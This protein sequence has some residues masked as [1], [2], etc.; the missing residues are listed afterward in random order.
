MYGKESSNIGITEPDYSK[1]AYCIQKF[2]PILVEG[3]LGQNDSLRC[4]S[5]LVLQDYRYEKTFC[6]QKWFNFLPQDREVKHSRL[7]TTETLKSV[8][9]NRYFMGSTTRG[10]L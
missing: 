3:A 9:V 7:K 2:G 8:G 4:Y 1:E 5:S 6:N 10:L